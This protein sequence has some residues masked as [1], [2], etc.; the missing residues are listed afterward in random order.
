MVLYIK[1]GTSSEDIQKI[2]SGAE[3]GTVIE[4]EAGEYTFTSTVKIETDNVV[5]RGA[6]DGQ[7][8]ITLDASMKGDP[9]FQVGDDLFKEDLGPDIGVTSGVKGS[10]SLTLASTDGVQVGD[11]LWIE[12][13]NTAALFAEIGDTQWQKDK[14]LQTQMVVVTSVDGKTVGFDSPL[15]F[16]FGKAAT[17]QVVDTVDNVTISNLTLKGDYGT[18]D[19][20]DFT[21][22]ISAEDDG[23][24]ILVNTSRGFT[25][26]DV[27][28][29]EPG[30][31]GLVVAKSIDAD[32]DG[33]SVSGAHNKGDS[34]N[35]YGLWIR[36]V[37]DSS[38]TDL[39]IVDTRHAVLFASYTSAS[40]NEVQVS[41][42]NRDINFH[43]GLD[44][45]NTISVDN[46]I[47]DT[48]AEQKALGLTLFV[49]EEGASYG[50]P[51][52]REANTVLFTTV[53]GSVRAEEITL[54][55]KGGHVQMYGS[56]DTVTG[57]A[58]NDYID[59]GTGTDVIV[60][61][62]GEDT[63]QGGS[64]TDTL[65]V[66]GG[67]A[68]LK[69]VQE[70]EGLWLYHAGGR[71]L[72]EKVEV[73]QTTDGTYSLSDDLDYLLKAGGYS[74]TQIPSDADVSAKDPA[75]QQEVVQ[76][77]VQADA[78]IA[79]D[80]APTALVAAPEEIP[81]APATAETS[82]E[83]GTETGTKTDVTQADAD[84]LGTASKDSISLSGGDSICFSLAG[85]DTVKA[86]DA[87][88]Y[89]DLGAGADKGNGA[90]GDD[91]ILGGDGNDVLRGNKGVDVLW[92]GEGNDT[93]YGNNDDDLLYG[94]A[95]NDKLNAG[96]GSATLEGGTGADKF[97]LTDGDNLIL[98]FSF[99]E[100]DSAYLNGHKADEIFKAALLW[101]KD[102][103]A[104][105]IFSFSVED[106]G[107]LTVATPDA[108]IEFRGITMDVVSEWYDH[109]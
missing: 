27:S 106:D 71:S 40:G 26:E 94:G 1:S 23:M 48:L 4:L 31:N 9:A 2:V 50:P 57:G 7:T 39:T 49:N 17:A 55:D 74:A 8:V 59:M 35:G 67:L 90:S 69:L 34:G 63:L 16:D 24:M 6:S 84:V 13:P 85:N 75:P 53:E 93:L 101:S 47:R 76:D 65:V 15:Q 98:D 32:I 72:L 37:Y 11:V 102:G 86:S 43:G 66:N 100:G 45:D 29:I 77:T 46:S 42:T 109:G 62:A 78:V 108:S 58:G 64:G 87:G 28:M 81:A 82:T 54:S 80:T 19:P 88:A 103:V 51:T 83:T 41:Y 36:D 38:F 92:G 10:Q 70:T 14:P 97:I 96:S 89:I 18:S 91:T 79:D 104:S 21:N 3:P 68:D 107:S 61:S 44:Q 33:L 12:T 52:E 73:L 5:L 20:T 30:S 22:T 56:A 60:L 99:E 25:L 105:D 95:G